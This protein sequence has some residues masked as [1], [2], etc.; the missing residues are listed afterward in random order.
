LTKVSRRTGVRFAGFFFFC[1]VVTGGATVRPGNREDAMT[2]YID[3]HGLSLALIGRSSVDG[4]LPRNILNDRS[5][6]EYQ[7]M[8]ASDSGA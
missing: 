3:R 1:V 8:C 2:T 7:E 5:D 6:R 4:L